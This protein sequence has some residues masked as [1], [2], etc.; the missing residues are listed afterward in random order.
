MADS[1]FAPLGPAAPATLFAGDLSSYSTGIGL[2]AGFRALG[3]DVAE[4]PM[5]EPTIRST[6]PSLRIAARVLGPLSARSYNQQIL[7][8]AE[9]SGARVMLTVKGIAIAPDTIRTLRQRGVLTVNFYPDYKFEYHGFEEAMFDDYDL[10][11]TTKSFQVDYLRR[12]LGDERVA[13]VHHGYVPEVHRRRGSLGA[14]PRYLWDVG[15][16]GNASAA[17]LAWLEPVART[18]GGRSMIIVGNDWEQL[19]KGTALAPYVFGAPLAGD[20]FA[21]VIEHS[22]INVAVHHGGGGAQ[23]WADLVSTRS[24]EIPAC[25]GFMLH[26]DNPEIRTLYEA[27]REMDVFSGPDELLAK[28]EHYLSNESERQTI[29]D[30]GHVRAVP[31]YS[32]HTR[33]AELLAVLKDRLPGM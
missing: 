12:R 18:L 23:G 17:K 21:R 13:M 11:V 6:L 16:I 33:A 9:R 32:L 31:A 25:G 14:P 1:I 30:A 29:A 7:D 26:V 28:V 8:M 4:A 15:Y 22:R 3:W 2:V 10:V 24:F 5:L 19:A 20:Q 27:G